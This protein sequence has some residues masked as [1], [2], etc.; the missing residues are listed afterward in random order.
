MKPKE[1]LEQ[2]EKDMPRAIDD[3]DFAYR[4]GLYDG[5]QR[6]WV[7]MRAKQNQYR[8]KHREEIR[9]Y[10]TQYQR[11]RR[12]RLKEMKEDIDKISAMN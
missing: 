1:Y 2:L 5:A 6:M 8:D 4:Q 10:N 9:A 7:L 12:A 3:L 11:E